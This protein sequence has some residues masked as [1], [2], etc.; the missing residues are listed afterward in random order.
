[1][2][3]RFRLFLA[4]AL[5]VP[6]VWLGLSFA[7]NTREGG[8]IRGWLT[9][10]AFQQWDACSNCDGVVPLSG[11]RPDPVSS[12]GDEAIASA[13]KLLERARKQGLCGLNRYDCTAAG[14]HI[15]SGKQICNAWRHHTGGAASSAVGPT[16]GEP[17]RLFGPGPAF[18]LHLPTT[19]RRIALLMGT[20]SS[21]LGLTRALYERLR[22]HVDVWA[23]NHMQYHPFVVPDFWHFE[24]M[25]QPIKPTGRPLQSWGRFPD[26][27]QENRQ[28][29][30]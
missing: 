8:T 22:P 26:A 13:E 3:R 30:S 19:G 21:V 18:E 9:R 14:A 10:H 16:L 2:R 12:A 28:V 1:M 29:C 17:V 20:G 27:P 23:L 7:A 5:L 25:S 6:M 11:I 24:P 15:P 4:A